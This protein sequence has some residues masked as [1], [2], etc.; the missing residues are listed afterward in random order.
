MK[1]TIRVA[2]ALLLITGCAT[3]PAATGSGIRAGFDPG[4]RACDDFYQHSIGTWLKENPIPPAFD[5][6]GSFNVLAEENRAKLRRILEEAALAGAPR[7]SDEQR[8]GDFWLTCVNEKAIE[9]QGLEPLADMLERIARIRNANDIVDAA[10]SLRAAGLPALFSFGGD[11]DLK[12]PSMNIAILGQASLGLPEPNYYTDSDDS[13]KR[14]R[15]AYLAYVTKLLELTGDESALAA[16]H[17]REIMRLETD[18][19]SASLTRVQRRDIESQYNIRTLA[20]LQAS[21]PAFDWTRWLAT[22]D[23][24]RFERLNVAHPRY[25][26]ELDRQLVR[27]PAEQWSNYLRF[28][29]IDAAAPYLSSDFNEAQF[30]FRGRVLQGRREQLPR[31]RRCVAWAD[32]FLPDALGRVYSAR[33][34][35]P[36]TRARALEMIE[37]LRGA[38]RTG[39]RELPWMS[40]ATKQNALTKLDAMAL[41]IGYPEKWRDY[42]TID[43]G[44]ASL[45]ANVLQGTRYLARQSTGKIGQPVDRTE[46]EMT[47][48]TVNAYNNPVLNEIVFSAGI[49]QPPFYDPAADDA[50]NYGGMGAVIGHELIHDFDDQG[51]KFAADGSLTDWWTAEDAARF[52]E[53]ASC[54]VEQFAEYDLGGGLRMDGKLVLGESMADLGGLEIAY[55]AYMKSIEGKPRRIVDGLTPEQRFFVGWSRIWAEN[56][57]PEAMEVKVKTD[58]HP[59]SRYRVNGP[60]SN[61]PEFAAAFGCN[62]N[63]PMVRT[64]RCEVW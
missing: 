21:T 49:L 55:A 58:P 50:Y 48:P 27:T 52:D 57:T 56:E 8:L 37:N 44:R 42:S 6:W 43:I 10:A 36:E 18:L 53:A 15:D 34:F 16:R 17:A 1:F 29:L 61:L 14:I 12:N 38:L 40:N 31:E 62:A 26:A 47:A 24:P 3:R 23:A 54:I 59:V 60:L 11:S 45:A 22:V 46:W 32:Q 30:E 4:V 25:F 41:K 51:R 9:Q 33:H 13:A 5:S 20:E 19:A 2:C 64:N 63:D 28:R 7:G 39:V 35:T